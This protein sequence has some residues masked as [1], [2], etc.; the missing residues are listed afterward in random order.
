MP[1]PSANDAGRTA[2]LGSG[3]PKRASLFVPYS[4]PSSLPP[5]RTSRLPDG[6]LPWVTFQREY[7][8][9]SEEQDV[10]RFPPAGALRPDAL[11]P[12]KSAALGIAAAFSFEILRFHGEKSR[13]DGRRLFPASRL[14]LQLFAAL[15]CE[16]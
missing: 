7:Y 5:L 1:A 2:Y 4:S 12:G 15:T 8:H 3:S 10:P 14:R 16:P 6:A 11:S 13:D 9:P